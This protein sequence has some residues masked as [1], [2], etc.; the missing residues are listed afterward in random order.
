M[1]DWRALGVAQAGSSGG[2]HRCADVGL[3]PDPT[4]SVSWLLSFRF[5]VPALKICRFEPPAA[6][7]G[8]P[9]LD[10]TSA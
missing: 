2:V 10:V 9:Q 7:W 6:S 1:Y 8:T 5:W 3:V 4:F